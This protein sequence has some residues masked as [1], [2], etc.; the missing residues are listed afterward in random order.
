[1]K[2]L[3]HIW[4]MLSKSLETI[5]NQQTNSLSASCQAAKAKFNFKVN[6]VIPV[7]AS[8]FPDPDLEP[9]SLLIKVS[10]FS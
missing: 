5:D 2:P 1:M 10:K 8:R 7:N 4:D 3:I 9:V 6:D